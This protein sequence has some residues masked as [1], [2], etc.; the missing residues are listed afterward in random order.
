MKKGFAAVAMLL[1]AASVAVA[2]E[3]HQGERRQG[4]PPGFVMMYGEP[5]ALTD[6]QKT[7]IGAV[8]KKTREDNAAFFASSRELMDQ[9]RAAREANDQAKLDELKPKVD[10]NR[11][12]MKKIRQAELERILPL[13]TADQ[14]AKFETLRKEHE[15]QRKEHADQH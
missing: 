3:R 11:E 7:D 1:L 5:L 15:A 13:L 10:A 12:Q 4:P 14:K 6:A 9:M 8:E 2:Q